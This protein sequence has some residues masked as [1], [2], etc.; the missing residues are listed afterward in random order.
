V[1]DGE[2]VIGY[3]GTGM[4]MKFIVES[5]VFGTLGGDRAAAIKMFC[6]GANASSHGVIIVV[7]TPEGPRHLGYALDPEEGGKVTEMAFAEEEFFVGALTNSPEAP[8]CCPDI[9]FKYFYDLDEGGQL[10]LLDSYRQPRVDPDTLAAETE[11]Q[12]SDEQACAQ[13]ESLTLELRSLQQQR[14]NLSG[15]SVEGIPTFSEGTFY[16]NLSDISAINFRIM[17]VQRALS[18]SRAAC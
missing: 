4:P 3:D 11:A 10:V 5:P 14:T 17:S 16:A 12:L 15:G 1:A 2:A 8:R 18:A 13:I 7:D 9:E 6:Q